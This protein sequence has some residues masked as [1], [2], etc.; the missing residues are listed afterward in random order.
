M[1][2]VVQLKR[3]FIRRVADVPA[4]RSFDAASGRQFNRQN[5]GSVSPETLA[6]AAPIRS[7]AR[8]AFAN[9]PWVR[10]GV[11]AWTTNL[12]GPGITPSSEDAEAAAAVNTWADVADADGITNFWGLQAAVAQALVVDGESFVH[13][14]YGDDGIRAR[15][16]PAEMVDEGLTSELGDGRFIIAGIEFDENGKRV[17]YHVLTQRPTDLYGSYQPPVRIPASDMLH[18]FKPLGAGQVRGVSWLAPILLTASEMDQLSDA[19]LVGAKVAAMFAG[20]LVDQNGSGGNVFEG[21]QTGSVL[22]GGLEP[23]TVKV[24]PPGFDLKFSAPEAAA[25]SI[26]FA[27]LTLESMAAG[28]GVPTHLLT[29]NLSNAN[30]SS[31]R[32]GLIDFRGRVSATQWHYLIPQLCEPTWRK[33]ITAEILDGTLEP[34]ALESKAEWLPPRFEW[35]DP[36]KD[37]EALAQEISLGLTSRRKAVAERGWDIEELDAEIADDRA[38]EARLGLQLGSAAKPAATSVTRVTKYRCERSHRRV[39]EVRSHDAPTQCRFSAFHVR[40]KGANGRG[41]LLDQRARATRKASAKCS[42][43]MTA[44]LI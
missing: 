28:L 41:R 8:Y 12:V 30:Y 25:G 38:R 9:N 6:A 3:P 20:F 39:R 42:R 27:K 2:L 11:A 18:V 34:S 29:G 33:V 19:L 43:T 21:T 35:T 32:A 14:T 44:P 24:I 22:E 37:V 15:I 17:A 10:S 13:F 4:V 26:E 40:R 31:L 5:F 1:G 16:I 7:R 36:A 23:G